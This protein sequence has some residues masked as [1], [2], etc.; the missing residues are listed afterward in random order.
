[1]GDW[2]AGNLGRLNAS[3]QAMGEA[4]RIKESKKN[5][6]AS[7][8]EGLTNNLFKRQS[9][10]AAQQHDK[11]MEKLMY[12]SAGEGTPGGAPGVGTRTSSQ[13]TLNQQSADLE[14]ASRSKS[15]EEYLNTMKGMGLD[16][17]LSQ[18]DYMMGWAP[19]NYYDAYKESDK[20]S[21]N[22]TMYIDAAFKGTNGPAQ[23]LAKDMEGNNQLDWNKFID[24]KTGAVDQKKVADAKA[25][26][27]SWLEGAI[28]DDKNLSRIFPAA[29]QKDTV[30]RY[31]ENIFNQAQGATG[32]VTGVSDKDLQSQYYQKINSKIKE[33]KDAM[34]S[35]TSSY[36]KYP[37]IKKF[38]SDTGMIFEPGKGKIQ[39]G[40]DD[41]AVK[42][43]SGGDVSAAESQL[44]EYQRVL[45]M[46]K[47]LGQ[48]P[49]K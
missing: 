19:A 37:E 25:A 7:I 33:I 36:M 15:Y 2:Q 46:I 1:M 41:S 5:R 48:N 29:Q 49:Y 14:S 26:M 28:R 17:Q 24:P 13:M 45:D 32:A 44:S 39:I 12:G 4:G 47:N 3:I 9:E 6:F 34:G 20:N 21:G 27:T 8:A 42:N 18:K 10:T 16:P 43:I 35:K 30:R 40:W 11:D 23:F 31:V 22:M 38:M